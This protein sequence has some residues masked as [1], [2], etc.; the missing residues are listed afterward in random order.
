[1]ASVI[2]IFKGS[3]AIEIDYSLYQINLKTNSSGL[4]I[5]STGLEI[6]VGTGLEITTNGLENTGVTSLQG[7]TGDITLT[8]GSGISIN[9]LTV[10]N[11][12]VV[13]F[14]G[15]TGDITLTEGTAITIDGNTI[16]IDVSANITWTG[17][18]VF[19]GGSALYVTGGN[20]SPPS[21][22]YIG[23]YVESNEATLITSGSQLTINAGGELYIGFQSSEVDV[24]FPINVNGIPLKNNGVYGGAG[25]STTYSATANMGAVSLTSGHYFQN[26]TNYNM[27][28]YYSGTAN[29]VV[30]NPGSSSGLTKLSTGYSSWGILASGGYIYFGSDAMN[31]N[32]WVIN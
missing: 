27:L 23:M 31:Y 28:V 12:G 26:G 1:M 8:A 14:Q 19:D 29:N 18:H 22:T 11:I 10:E 5:T 6:V 15:S 24:F 13:S 2:E 20:S 9:G 21:S 7:N 3:D 30:G 25:L 16:S 17:K 4:N 32:W